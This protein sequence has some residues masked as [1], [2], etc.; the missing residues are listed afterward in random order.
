[1]TSKDGKPV[2]VFVTL[3]VL[4][5]QKNRRIHSEDYKCS[6]SRIIFARLPNSLIGLVTSGFAYQIS[7]GGSASHGV[8]S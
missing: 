2:E 6:W 4:R 8:V 3:L 7:S 1:V 5:E